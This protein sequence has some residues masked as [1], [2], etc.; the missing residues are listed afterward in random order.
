MFEEFAHGARCLFQGFTWLT[1]PGVRRY[2][3][4]PLLI[5]LLL[6]A[7]AIA[8]GAR[9]FDAWLVHWISGLPHW[10]AWLT[11]VLWVVFALA[12]AVVLFYAFALL[13]NLI[14]APLDIFLAMRIEA[15]ITG[16]R[17][18]TGRSLTMDIVVGLRSQLQRLLYL[19]WRM[20]LIAVVGLVLLFVPL[21]GALT[22][23]LWFVF[24]AWTLAIVY[25]DFPLS[26]RGVTFAEQR[27]L[28]RQ[29]RAR[30]FG[31]GAAAALCTMVPVVNFIIMPAAVAGATVLWT[32][33]P[34]PNS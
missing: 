12:A 1:C 15:M 18:E 10:L 3:I 19:V 5:N 22:P 28:F 8:L 32:E 24:T 11:A 4:L 2:V 7:A 31:F 16:R 9:Y 30:L 20:L 25:S 21:F 17:P 34:A 23:L 6:F 29:K 13:A 27:R 14:A 26:N 33:S